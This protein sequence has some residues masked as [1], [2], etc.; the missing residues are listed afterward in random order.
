MVMTID[1]DSSSIFYVICR[2]LIASNSYGYSIEMHPCVYDWAYLYVHLE[3]AK[4]VFAG[5]SYFINFL[6]NLK[7]CDV[8]ATIQSFKLF[9]LSRTEPLRT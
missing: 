5:A 7:C 9:N 1:V 6:E 4:F 3:G 2:A 8:G